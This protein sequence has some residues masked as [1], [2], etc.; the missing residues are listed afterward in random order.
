[1][2]PL[3]P[4]PHFFDFFIFLDKD[5]HFFSYCRDVKN[6]A[7]IAG[8]FF[9]DYPTKNAVQSVYPYGAGKVRRDKLYVLL[10]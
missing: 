6:L 9:N 5:H 1:M 8:K 3:S 10:R 7:V 2:T 4:S